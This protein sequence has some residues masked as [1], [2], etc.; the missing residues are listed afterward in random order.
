MFD[1]DKWQEIYSTI[2]KHKLRTLLTAFGVFWGIF[3]LVLLLGAGKGLEN[4]VFNMFSSLANNTMFIFGGRTRI[5]YKGLPPGRN[6]SFTNDDYLAIKRELPEVKYLAP[7]MRLTG[8]YNVS[9]GIK[10]NPF[11]VTGT[12]PDYRN[13]KAL[14]FNFGRFLNE[15]D[16]E[17]KRK[18]TVI[19]T[20]V[21]EVLFGEEN[22]IGKY[23][24]IKGVFFKVIGVFSVQFSGNNGRDET[25]SLYIPL[26]TLQQSFNLPDKIGVF[27]LSTHENVSA[28]DAEKK[29][30]TLLA[31]RH[32]VDPEDEKAMGGWNS[33]KEVQ[34][35]VSLF[36]GIKIFIWI[37]G[38]GTIIAGIV[39]VSNIML[40]IVKERTREIG[41]RKALGATPASIISLI[42]TEA[43]VITATSGYM[44]LVCGVFLLEGIKNLM[45][46]SGAENQYF[47]N[48]EIDVQVAITA[49][50][51][52]VI[53]GALA[54]LYPAR[55]ASKVS[56]IEALRAD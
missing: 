21:Q 42:I 14:E 46:K 41:I 4:G 23:V 26:T 37:V 11:Q 7:S 19:G 29:V 32:N 2:Q 43:I 38:I 39:G 40:I 17:E 31:G 6:I 9:F 8:N 51:I 15:Q 13:I 1:L 12:L 35:F 36:T 56:P 52:L 28:D 30:K 48:P 5:P 3:M 49:T 10:S 20:R 44:G 22:P 27:I 25:E 24:N 34:K 16:I 47:S 54:G 55:K 53:A 18:V 45:A 50:V 33:G